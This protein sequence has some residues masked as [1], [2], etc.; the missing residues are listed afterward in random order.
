MP[1]CHVFKPLDNPRAGSP[2]LVP[3]SGRT[4][5]LPAT[6]RTADQLYVLRYASHVQYRATVRVF[7]GRCSAPSLDIL[8]KRL[9]LDFTG[10]E[11]D[12]TTFEAEFE[13]V[14]LALR[15]DE[16]AREQPPEP[17]L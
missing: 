2:A 12:N 3:R 11:T 5:R 8:R 14:V 4:A 13:K 16:G 6:G 17:K 1:G 15:A 7:V 10:W 9:A